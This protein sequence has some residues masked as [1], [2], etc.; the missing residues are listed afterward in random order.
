MSG[1]RVV[2]DTNVLLSLWVFARTPRGSELMPLRKMVDRGDLLALGNPGCLAEFRRVLG[3]PDFAL[4][5]GTQQEIYEEY[6][7]VVHP[8]PPGMTDAKPLPRCR[9][10]DD[11]QF[12]ELARDGG[13]DYLVTADKALLELARHRL[14]RGMF[15]IVTPERFM[16]FMMKG[17]EAPTDRPAAGL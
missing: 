1:L 11:Q 15:G 12:L 10:V 14:L 2:L 13:A 5:A 17:A 6:L 8:M 9:D 4:A 7:R 3:Y 16:A